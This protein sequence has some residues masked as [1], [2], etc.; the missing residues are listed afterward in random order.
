MNPIYS[1]SEWKGFNSWIKELMTEKYDR[2]VPMQISD[3]PIVLIFVCLFRYFH[4]IT[5]AITKKNVD[6]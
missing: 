5:P 6:G 2:T 4:E 3:N 1:E